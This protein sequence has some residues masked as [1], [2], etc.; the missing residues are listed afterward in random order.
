MDIQGL[1]SS[2][3]INF[4]C[5]SKMN[6]EQIFQ[7]LCYTVQRGVLSFFF[8]FLLNLVQQNCH[9]FTSL[10]QSVMY[11]IDILLIF[12]S[13]VTLNLKSHCNDYRQREN[14]L[15]H[16]V[17]FGVVF[18]VESFIGFAYQFD[19]GLEYRFM[20]YSKKFFYK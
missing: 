10:W 2:L 17:D 4:Y 1:S 8:F 6:G 19:W 18:I 15:W 13:C 16:I 12:C 14:A 5:S 11:F 3:A 7:S 20:A 9:L